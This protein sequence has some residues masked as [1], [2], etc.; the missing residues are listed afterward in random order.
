MLLKDIVN[1]KQILIKN[2]SELIKLIFNK[3]WIYK[4]YSSKYIISLDDRENRLLYKKVLWEWHTPYVKSKINK[5]LY[6][7]IESLNPT[8]SF[9][10]RETAFLFKIMDKYWLLNEFDRLVVCSSWNAAISSVLYS[11]YYRKKIVV[12]LSKWVSEY[13]I[14]ILKKLWADIQI[15]GDDYE[16]TY[17]YLV[18][19]T[20]RDRNILN[21]TTWFIDWKDE[22][23]KLISYELNKQL[24]NSEIDYVI[25]PVWNWSLLFGVWKWFKE[26]KDKWIIK[27]MPV[28]YGVQV[29]NWSPF[30]KYE[31]S[32]KYIL[33]K[34][35]IEDSKADGI[36]ARESYN[37]LKVKYLIDKWE[38]IRFL[39]INEKDIMEWYNEFLKEWLLVEYTSA[40]VMWA[41]LRY[42]EDIIDI[43]KV[44]VL[45][46][47]WSG[48]KLL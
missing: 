13:K 44:W 2:K 42:K 28:I 26:L 39:Y 5:N 43:N 41:Y 20:L 30:K 36:L 15:V 37:F 11:N 45:I 7:K 12:Y 31:E 17:R 27:R 23:N 33:E 1:D 25:V 48:L 14:W 35:E 6:Y 21:I 40:V 3:E 8:W 18:D 4:Y 34:N 46:V 19:Y 10:D 16:E 32:G 9:K 22:A 24:K 47:T 29:I 38:D